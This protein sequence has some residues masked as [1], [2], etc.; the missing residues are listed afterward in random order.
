MFTTLRFK[1]MVGTI[2]ILLAITGALVG[3]QLQ[4]AGCA[5]QVSDGKGSEQTAAEIPGAGQ[6]FSWSA[7]SDCATCHTTEK[8]SLGDAAQPQAIAHESQDCNSC[9]TEEAILKQA[10]EG[11]T[12]GSTPAKKA[13]VKTVSEQ[14]CISCHG[15]LAA[16]AVKTADSDALTDSNGLS[17]NPHERPDGERHAENP[18]TCTDCHKVHSKDLSKDAMKYCAQCHHRGIFQCGTCHPADR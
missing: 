10:H 8:A 7:T 13:R 17:V 15:D 1:R 18:A 5:P 4:L 9:H 14:T 6:S 16:V 12:Y 3:A 2:L 11:V